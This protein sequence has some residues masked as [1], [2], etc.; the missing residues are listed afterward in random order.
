MRWLFIIGCG[1]AAVGSS[2]VCG[3][4]WS[5]AHPIPGHGNF[6]PIILAVLLT[7]V[8]AGVGSGLAAFLWRPHRRLVRQTGLLLAVGLLG[9]LAIPPVVTVIWDANDKMQQQAN[10]AANMDPFR[11]TAMKRSQDF[12]R[13]GMPLYP[14]R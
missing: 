12:R 14:T 8:T 9:S 4:V 6:F 1:L 2:W 7:P 3:S 11:A 13:A 10:R 5:N